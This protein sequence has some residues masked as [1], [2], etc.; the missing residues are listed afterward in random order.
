MRRTTTTAHAILGLLALRPQWTTWELT[1][2]MGRNLRFFWPRAASRIFAEARSLEASGLAKAERSFVGR[3]ARTSYRITDAGRESLSH[4][5]A[6]PPGATTLESETVL[7]VFLADL[8]GADAVHHIRAA[9]ERVRADAH[10]ILDVGRVAGP[11]YLDG[12]APFQDQIHVRALV[13]DFLSHHAR[14]LLEWADRTEAAVAQWDQQ[15]DDARAAAAREHI[16][17]CLAAFPPAA[18]AAGGADRAGGAAGAAGR[19]RRAEP[20]REP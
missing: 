5:L 4:W 1:K 6:T 3:R 19:R 11:E 7:R 12:R 18:G 10:A 20:E 9:L 16:A 8:S 17:R 2:Q 13:F 14:M 15:P